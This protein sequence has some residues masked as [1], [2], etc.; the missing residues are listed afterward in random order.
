MAPRVPAV[1]VAPALIAGALASCG[2]EWTLPQEETSTGGGG[3]TSTGGEGGSSTVV[4]SSHA[5]ATTSGAATSGAATTSSS[6][7]SAVTTGSGAATS[8]QA[9]STSSGNPA[10]DAL[11]DC[12]ACWGCS[13]DGACQAQ[14]QA[15]EQDPS[16]WDYD[17]CLASCPDELCASACGAMVPPST[18]DVWSDWAYC[19]DCQCLT[20]C[21]GYCDSW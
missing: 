11:G 9:S 3:A 5:A 16:C 13:S 17:A 10:C 20:S 7:T 2:L 15:C 14:T 19:V 18:I 21:P 8:A 1:L 6:S 4:T 12:Q